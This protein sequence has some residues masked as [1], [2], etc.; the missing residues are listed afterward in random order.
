MP[1]SV[2][3]PIAIS[4]TATMAISV[5]IPI[6][7][8]ITIPVAIPVSRELRLTNQDAIS[9]AVLI[10]AITTIVAVTARIPRAVIT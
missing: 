1:I 6:S 9:F 5:A 8:T 2:A 4:I 10:R 3:I 7:V